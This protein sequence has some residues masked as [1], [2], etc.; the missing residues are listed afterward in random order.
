MPKSKKLKSDRFSI[1][2]KSE[3]ESIE[4]ETTPPQLTMTLNALIKDAQRVH[5]FRGD[6]SYAL[7][8]FLREVDTILPLLD[9]N[10]P[11]KNYV[12]QRVIVNKIQGPALDVIRTLGQSA[13]WEDIKAAL[14]HNFGVRKT[15]HQLY[16][17]ALSA[18]NFQVRNYFTILKNI[19]SELNEKYDYDAEKPQ[20]F[21]PQ[22]NEEMMLKTFINNIDSN[23]AS[24]ILNR[25]INSLREAF[26]LLDDLGM[27]R[28]NYKHNFKNNVFQQTPKFP[29][30]NKQDFS[31]KSY[32]NPNLGQHK[33]QN[34]YN[35]GQNSRQTRQNYTSFTRQRSQNRP[36]PMDVDHIQHEVN[37][38][39]TPPKYT[40]Q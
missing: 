13:T 18:T 1:Y 5:E 28:N 11:A 10:I 33:Q 34:T 19:L 9:N 2:V 14:I 39:L 16:H 6:G 4:M 29:V 27:I 17:Q 24:I 7:T 20:Q 37:F 26:N 21:S 15:Y 25:K 8:S 30:N 12:Y 22:M 36:Q 40:Y 31:K 35:F 38:Q 32:F 23:L 3:E